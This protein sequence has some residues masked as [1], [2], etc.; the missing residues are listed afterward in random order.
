MT[1]LDFE[2]AL[3]LL[4]TQAAL[5]PLPRETE[6]LP[7]LESL[8]R[9][10]ATTV[11]AP[12]D[13]PPFD[14]STR[15]GFSVRSADSGPRV[16]VGLIKAGD[17]WTGPMLAV[18]QAIEIMTGA[19]VPEGADAVAMLEHVTRTESH[20]TPEPNRIWTPGENVVPRGAE[21]RQGQPVIPAGT[22]IT[23]AGVAL[24]ASCG[25]AQLTVYRR[26][27][28]AIVATGDELVE[29]GLDVPVEPQQIYNSNSHALAALVLAAGAEPLRLRI[30]ADTR[31]AVAASLELAR[32]A[33]LILFSGGVSMGQYD[34][35]EEVLLAAGAE[36]HFTGVRM[37][38]GKPVVFGSL[39][40]SGTPRK[41]CSASPAT[42]SPP[43]SPFTPSSNLSSALLPVPPSPALAGLSPTSPTPPSSK[44]TSPGSFPPI[45]PEQTSTSFPG[46]AP[47][48][49]PPTP[50]PTATPNSP[51]ARPP[52]HPAPQSASSFA[53]TDSPSPLAGHSERSEEPP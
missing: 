27:R 1:T 42:P 25:C 43:R 53:R 6:T 31:E 2:S 15:D 23:P 16:V 52:W 32:G 29:V 48:T 38:P 45:S 5:L 22:L 33:D 7:L 13:Q 51:P 10:L 47:E 41:Y 36:F 44:P 11:T 30:T 34:L 3:T 9:V 14:R 40:G 49:S 20:I 24:A 26:P 37:Q 4:A 12:R 39:P 46:K 8:N 21:A 19:P 28:V 35:V 18:S 50:A 17:L